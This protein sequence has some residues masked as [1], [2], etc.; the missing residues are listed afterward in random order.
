MTVKPILSTNR[1]LNPQR[2]LFNQLK[3]LFHWLENFW[4]KNLKILRLELLHKFLWCSSLFDFTQ[5]P[6]VGLYL[7]WRSRIFSLKMIAKVP[8]YTFAARESWHISMSML[9]VAD[10]I[11]HSRSRSSP[12]Y[13]SLIIRL[14]KASGAC[15]W[16]DIFAC[17][18]LR[19]DDYK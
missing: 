5:I 10:F 14:E 6:I 1:K 9:R 19:F 7:V 16:A 4:L 12:G 18:V 2:V 8:R 11:K 15:I 17:T 3:V 13:H